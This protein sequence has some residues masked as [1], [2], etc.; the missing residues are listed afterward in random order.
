MVSSDSQ[1]SE[2]DTM[3]IDMEGKEV[4]ILMKSESFYVFTGSRW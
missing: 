3:Q 4:R 1:K 2:R